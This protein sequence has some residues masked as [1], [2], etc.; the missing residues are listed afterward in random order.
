MHNPIHD[1]IEEKM[2]RL[3]HEREIF[4]LAFTHSSLGVPNN[5]RLAFIGDAVLSL[6]I[7]EHLFR[8]Y[9]DWRSR[10]LH[11]MSANKLETGDNFARHATDIGLTKR[12]KYGKSLRPDEVEK[13]VEMRAEVFEAYFGAIYLTEGLAGALEAAK[14][15]DVV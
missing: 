1:E 7:R 5:Q 10:D 8:E 2:R 12:L 11:E 3:V 13:S 6:I 15:F 14:R 4:D 9:P